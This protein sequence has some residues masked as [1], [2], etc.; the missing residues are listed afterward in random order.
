L[1]N[2]HAENKTKGVVGRMG[3]K[4][5]IIPII[6]DKIPAVETR[7]FRYFSIARKGRKILKTHSFLTFARKQKYEYGQKS[8]G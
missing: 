1:R 5:P 8:I 4:I 7:Y 6:N 2:N 3:T